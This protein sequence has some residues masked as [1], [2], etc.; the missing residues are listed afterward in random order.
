MRVA[1]PASTTADTTFVALAELD[2]LLELE[3][4]LDELLET[5]ELLE[6]AEL[7]AT[8]E[9]L[10]TDEL[11]LLAVELELEPPPPHAAKPAVARAMRQNC[12]TRL[13]L[14]CACMMV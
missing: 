6:L 10:E 11:A 1:G 8:D 4:L 3:E 2:E 7:L 14:T 5:E 13:G 12:N 9:L